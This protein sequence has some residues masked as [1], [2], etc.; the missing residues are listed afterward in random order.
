MGQIDRLLKEILQRLKEEEVDIQELQTIKRSFLLA[1]R[2][3]L[4]E[5]H[6]Q[7]GVPRWSDY[8]KMGNH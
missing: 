3:A 2:E 5:N 7:H 1:K 4:N 8:L 6:W